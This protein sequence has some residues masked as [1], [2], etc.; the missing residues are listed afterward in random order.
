MR[1]PLAPATTFVVGK[2]VAVCL[3]AKASHPAET[4]RRGAKCSTE[5][6]K[7][8]GL[9]PAFLQLV[10]SALGDDRRLTNRRFACTASGA[11]QRE[12]GGGCDQKLLHWKAP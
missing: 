7:K 9:R 5:R 8:A 11:Q 2:A 3:A 4:I 1:P 6:N 10:A 12:N